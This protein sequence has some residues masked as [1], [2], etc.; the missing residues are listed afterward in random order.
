VELREHQGPGNRSG[1]KAQGAAPVRKRAAA[2]T[3][4]A[5]GADGYSSAT[6]SAQKN[7]HQNGRNSPQNAQRKRGAQGES[8]HLVPGEHLPVRQR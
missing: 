3:M 4:P 7:P 6:A 8:R 2:A 1:E 5:A